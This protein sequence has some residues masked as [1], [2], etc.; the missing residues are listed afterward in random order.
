M[1]ALATMAIRRQ[2][3]VSVV[4]VALVALC[5]GLALSLS[6]S[7]ANAQRTVGQIAFQRTVGEGET[8]I[9]VIND[10]GSGARRIAEGS[11][12]DWSPDGRQVAYS[13]S[14][15]VQSSPWMA[16]RPASLPATGSGRTGHRMER[17][18]RLRVTMESTS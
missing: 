10:D 2:G 14:E 4:G 8:Q 7:V 6:G 5:V 15:G 18:L 16:V 12:P 3:R 11:D 17:G 9:Y 13:S 1:R